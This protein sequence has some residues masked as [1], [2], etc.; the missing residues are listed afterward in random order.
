MTDT[1]ET[2]WP[3]FA[4]LVERGADSFDPVRFCYI[5][6]LARR[7]L[8]L[9]GAVR[10]IV[11]QKAHEALA[12]Y[13]AR[14]DRARA[15]A[16]DIVAR[17]SSEFPDSADNLESLF[18][19]YAFKEVKR[20]GKRLERG[21]TRSALAELTQQII[22]GDIHSGKK[23]VELTF[24]E[25]LQQQENKVIRSISNSLAQQPSDRNE[26]TG[27]LNS[28]RLIKQ[29]WAKFHSDRLVSISND[30]CPEN[31]GHLNSQMLVTRSLSIMRD[32]SA[33]YLNRFVLYID[34]LLWLERA[35][36]GIEAEASSV[37]S[38]KSNVRRG[39]HRNRQPSGDGRSG[40]D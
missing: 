5:E 33:N 37:S 15:E 23:S 16:V 13:Q 27:E 8:K 40:R 14:L 17:V 30:A 39:K 31:S 1:A 29:T 36:E 2:I 7:S 11:E 20:L 25:L 35:G 18:K 28:F 32:I 34:T 10:R 4:S 12:D 6:S 26:H 22:D 21:K 3:R 38:G 19:K 9:Q 24:D